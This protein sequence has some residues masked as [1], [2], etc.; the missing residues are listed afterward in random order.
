MELKMP[1][2]SLRIKCSFSKINFAFF[3]PAL[4]EVALKI[5]KRVLLVH[6]FG[7]F[8]RFLNWFFKTFLL[9]LFKNL[10]AQLDC[11]EKGEVSGP[12]GAPTPTICAPANHIIV[13]FLHQFLFIAFI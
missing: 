13:G 9:N 8:F 4:V 5:F 7:G 11:I 3:C 10:R 2:L 6:C 1:N 12:P